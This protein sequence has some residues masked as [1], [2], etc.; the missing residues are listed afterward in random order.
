[1]YVCMVDHVCSL[2]SNY[3]EYFNLGAFIDN[4][5]ETLPFELKY[6]YRSKG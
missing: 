3:V 1:M 4:T 2:P 5:D 6:G